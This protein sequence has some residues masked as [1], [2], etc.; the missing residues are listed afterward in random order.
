MEL[1]LI[2]KDQLKVTLS[3]ADMERYELRPEEL[4]YG[5][6]ETRSA[7]WSILDRAKH[8]TGF[9][10]ASDRVLVQ[11]YPSVSGGCE[12]FVTKLHEKKAAG[13]SLLPKNRRVCL[14][15]W[16]MEGIDE[17]LAACGSIAGDENILESSAYRMDDGSYILFLTGV[18]NESASL[19]LCESYACLREYGKPMDAAKAMLL[20]SEHGRLLVDRTAVKLLGALS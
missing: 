2:S 10:A 19:F 11:V 6:T 12:L 14:R 4:D 13:K 8:E 7:F 16:R 3:A 18:P 1:L 15:A 17:L 5:N 20:M 9:D